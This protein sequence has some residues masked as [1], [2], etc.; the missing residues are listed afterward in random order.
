MAGVPLSLG[1]TERYLISRDILTDRIEFDA[2]IMA[3]EDV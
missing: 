1:D 3:P 2:A